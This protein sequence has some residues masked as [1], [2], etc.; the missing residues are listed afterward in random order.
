MCFT[1]LFSA[2]SPGLLSGI[3]P[4]PLPQQLLSLLAPSVH[5]KGASPGDSVVKSHLPMQGTEETWVRFLG[6][7]ESLEEGVKTH[8]SIL[9]GKIPWTEEPG[10]LQ[11]IGWQ[12]V[13]HD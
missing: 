8:S 12:R 3:F 13:R 11:S 10:G 2:G 6:Q 1:V 9:A 7:E 5:Q 4:H